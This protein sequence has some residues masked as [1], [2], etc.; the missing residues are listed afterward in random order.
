MPVVAVAGG[1][2]KLG[3]TIVEA[4]AKNK[5]HSLIVLSRKLDPSF[6]ATYGVAIVAVDYHDVAALTKVLEEHNVYTVVSALTMG[7]APDGSR[8][9]EIELI[10]AADASKTTKRMISSDWGIP[11]TDDHIPKLV[12]VIHKLEAQ[13]VL[14]QVCNLE[15]TYFLIGFYLDYWGIPGVKSNMGPFPIA[16]DIPNN[17]AAIPGTGDTPITFTH[18]TDV[19]KFVSA[20]LD[21]DEWDPITYVGGDSVTWNQFLQYAEDAKGS[22]FQTTFDSIEKLKS[23]ECTELPS[24]PLAYSYVP[25]KDFQILAAALGEW[26]SEGVFNFAPGT[27]LNNRLPNIETIKVKDML[28]KAWKQ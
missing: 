15:T 11:H 1:T 20:F 5:N 17:T 26:T 4:I 2:G 22:K 9:N 8:P 18:S 7:P 14:K 25:K 13:E 3:R 19:A 6:E 16:I 24:Q 21:L 10:K 23:G 28:D 12:S 27:L